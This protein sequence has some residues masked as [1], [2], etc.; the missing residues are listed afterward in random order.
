MRG[1]PPLIYWHIRVLPSL[2]IATRRTFSD[3]DMITINASGEF[4]RDINRRREIDLDRELIASALRASAFLR[5]TFKRCMVILD[6]VRRLDFRLL[7][8][9]EISFPW[10]APR[11]LW[12]LLPL[13]FGERRG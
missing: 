6:I 12:L 9:G 1:S 5:T 7:A 4:F 8:I 13:V 2:P 3:F 11:L 10:F